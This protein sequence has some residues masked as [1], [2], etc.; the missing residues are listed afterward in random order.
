MDVFPSPEAKGVTVGK[1]PK[2]G[3]EI[4]RPVDASA[5]F[6][7]Q[8]FKTLADPFVG[9]ISLLKVYSGTPL[10]RVFT[11]VNAN[12]DKTARPAACP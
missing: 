8:V 2:D 5:P 6:S 4:S 3:S 1:N 7:A 10:D 11:F 12:N 9:K